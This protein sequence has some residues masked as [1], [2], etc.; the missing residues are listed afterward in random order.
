[1]A[2]V[3]VL[4][5]FTLLA[6]GPAGGTVWKGTIPPSTRQSIVY[7]PPQYTL[8]HRYPV[9]FLLHGMPG[10]PLGFVDS[11]RLAD[12]ADTLGKPIVAV[13]PAAGPDVGYRGEWAGRWE[14]YV[15]RNVVP[16]ATTGL[17]AGPRTIAGVSAGGYGAVDI[18]LRH[19]GLFGTVE[20]WGGYFTP[21]AD[22]PLRGAS[23]E[24]MQAHDPELLIRREASSFRRV[25]FFLSSGPTHGDVLQSGTR[26]FGLELSHL[27]IP[28]VTW[29]L[30]TAKADWRAQLTQG[31]RYAVGEPATS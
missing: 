6:T 22:G 16:W 10:G 9:V 20:S 8:A 12:T 1:V 14:D 28:H 29:L 2:I 21:F 18:A 15:V 19:P 5:A 17:S 27:R 7:L 30:H 13:A 3:P 24:Q 25:R 26:S 23:R 11:L 4:A 31:L